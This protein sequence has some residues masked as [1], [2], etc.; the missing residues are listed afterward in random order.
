MESGFC[1]NAINR[2]IMGHD[3]FHCPGLI[4]FCWCWVGCFCDGGLNVVGVDV[5]AGAKGATPASSATKFARAKSVCNK[6][7]AVAVKNVSKVV[8]ESRGARFGKKV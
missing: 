3:V 4:V 7:G 6:N 5:W 2:V 1:C 8:F